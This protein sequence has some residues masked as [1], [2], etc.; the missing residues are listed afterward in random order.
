LETYRHGAPFLIEKTVSNC[1]RVPF[2]DA[3]FPNAKYMFL[4]RDGRDVVESAYRQWIAPPDWNYLLEKTRSF[5][6]LD[7]PGY[8]LKYAASL[9]KKCGPGIQKTATW[10][11][12]Y[13]G[14]DQDLATKDLIE[15][16]AIQWSR[17]TEKAYSSLQTLD[18]SRAMQV[19]YEDFVNH[20]QPHLT[21]IADFLGVDP[22]PYC[23]KEIIDNI[24]TSNV[25]KG[26]RQLSPAQQ[27]LAI[28]AIQNQLDLLGYGY[29]A[30]LL[31]D[32]LPIY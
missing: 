16:C 19:T 2:V 22:D 24:S 23:E 10:G 25:G 31:Q 28:N 11:P 18:Q 14:I 20:P 30:P 6:I 27:E 12:R 21:R 3:I 5:P 1:L 7:A 17:S 13:Q 26:W 32:K 4:F 15:V 9:I 29:P 8:A